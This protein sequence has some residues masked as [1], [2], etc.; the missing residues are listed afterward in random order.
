MRVVAGVRKQ[1][2][3]TLLE[4]VVVMTLLSLLMTGLIS[5]M[6]TMAQTETKVDQRLQRLDELRTTRAF[7]SKVMG[8]MSGAKITQSDTGNKLIVPFHATADSVT[9]VGILPPRATTGGRSYF[10]LQIERLDGV[11]ALV[12]RL[13]PCGPDLVFPDWSSAESHVLSRDAVALQVHA[14]GQSTSASA[15]EPS[16][17]QG[18]QPGWPVADVLPEQL[19]LTLFDGARQEISTWT[20]AVHP[21]LQT[22]DSI[23]LVT[24][25][26]G[27][28]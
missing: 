7:L 15:K 10:R 1:G 24:I 2:G 3:F 25:G 4:L 16:W 6:R 22:D 26:G 13:V 27:R 23:S 12:L 9:W 5:A 8:Q 17:P 19:R 14:Q 11:E 18:W 21:F 28:N 20:F